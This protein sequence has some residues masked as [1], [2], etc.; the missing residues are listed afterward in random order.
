MAVIMACTRLAS[1]RRAVCGDS[2]DDGVPRCRL[3]S[4]AAANLERVPPAGGVL[5]LS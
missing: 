2:I 3:R 5:M 4:D 1:E